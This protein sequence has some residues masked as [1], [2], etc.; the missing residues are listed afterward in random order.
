MPDLSRSVRALTGVLLFADLA[1][2]QTT[3]IVDANNG[4]GAHFTDLPP[5]VAAAAPGDVVVVRYVDPLVTAY[6]APNIAKGLTLVATGA[7][8]PGLAGMFTIGGVPAGEHVVV[9]GFRLAPFVTGAG[10]TGNCFLR[11]WFNDGSVHFQD[12]VRDP[13]F[14]LFYT[15]NGLSMNDDRLVTFSRCDLPK[16]TQFGAQFTDCAEVV[17][18]RSAMGPPTG[19]GTT[20]ATLSLARSR[21]VLQESTVTGF[22]WAFG[23]TPAIAAC[24]ATIELVGPGAVVSTPGVGPAIVDGY[25]ATCAG[26]SVVRLGPGATIAPGAPTTV[27]PVFALGGFVGAG[28]QLDLDVYGH[29][30]G[31]AL[32]SFG[33]PTATPLP[34]WGATYYLDAST[35]VVFD[36]LLLDTSGRA[37]W[38]AI[39]PPGLPVGLSLWLQ[40]ASI[41]ALG[42]FRLSTPAIV[43]TQ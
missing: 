43:T 40:A 31:V 42:A 4:P 33:Q 24:D 32:L 17:L 15:Q 10:T 41:D 37:T 3:W 12:V 9:R 39:L 36:A 18:D 20:V 35:V 25:G 1:A 27:G 29:A 14:S 5:A 21:L 26:A 34:L 11:V 28:A 8:R 13:V 38:Q 6:T 22:G 30:N 2:A 23:E 19:G 7:D 16:V